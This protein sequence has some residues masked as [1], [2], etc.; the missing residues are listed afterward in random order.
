ME[1]ALRTALR[2]DAEP[3]VTCA[4][5]TDAGVHARGQVAHVDV[6]DDVGH[7]LPGL[8]RSIRGLLPEDAWLVDISIVPGS[9]DARFS[10]L[11]RHYRYRICDDPRAWD[12]LRRH[13][14]VQHPRTLDLDVMNVAAQPLLGEHDFAALCRPREGATTIRRLLTIDWSR[15]AAGLAQM[16]VSADA[17]CHSMV[18][19]L[20]GL[21]LPVGEGRRPVDWPADVVRLGVR[22]SGV[23]VMPAHGLVLEGVAYPAEDEF[24][25]RQEVTRAPR[26]A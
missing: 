19:S 18:R 25:A 12:P 16:R 22:D 21:L 23:Q 20:V 9:F 8:A 26:G 15:S 13:W 1:E 14:V 6:G 24:A 5:R 11:S 17:F 3:Q 2:S 10:A 4:G 7:D